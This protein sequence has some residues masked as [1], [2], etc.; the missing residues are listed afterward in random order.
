MKIALMCMAI[1]Y[2]SLFYS[3][4]KKEIADKNYN[5][6]VKFSF[7]KDDCKGE[8]PCTVYFKN[9]TQGDA[10][11][12]WDFG[13]NSEV[14]RRANPQ[15]TYQSGDSFIVKLKVIFKDGEGETTK[16]VIIKE[17]EQPHS[18]P[19]ETIGNFACARKLSS[20]I[21]SH[22]II[23]NE[24]INYYYFNVDTAG[25]VSIKID[26][27]PNAEGGCRFD[28]DLL[29]QPNSSSTV[30]TKGTGLT[31]ETIIMY[32]GPL[33][34]GQY[35]IRLKESS[36]VKSTEKFNITY[37]FL[38][39]DINELNNT[40]YT[41]TNLQDG[42]S[43]KGTILA[44]GDVDYY[45][46]YQAKP[47][48]VDIVLNP[49][50]EFDRASDLTATA[51]DVANT[52]SKVR[53]ITKPTGEI[54]KLSVGPLDTGYHYIALS[55]Y[56]TYSLSTDVYEISA[57]FDT[58]DV[59]EPNNT[60]NVATPINAGQN[61]KGTLKAIEDV[62]IYAYLTTST[63]PITMIVDKVPE[64]LYNF[65]ISL[66][67]DPNQTALV[68]SKKANVGETLTFTSTQPIIL[69]KHYYIKISAYSYEE[70]DEPYIIHVS[71]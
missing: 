50:P 43:L 47:G 34:V 69:G 2:A 33:T 24:K 32:G 61:Y 39:T 41:A 35:Y 38:N 48:V 1:I 66:Y 21:T 62:D 51:F 9:E 10:A 71:Q 42:K 12:E 52:N 31:G 63:Q 27:V 68:G 55:A 26:A 6:D 16:T 23:E 60:F 7:T 45:K 20:G 46:Y 64:Y 40:F 22:G 36:S 56:Y 28:V 65:T 17:P 25:A 58:N 11:Y 57:T 13:D 5:A 37:T 19:C 29:N 4:K 3:C 44:A 70:S 53:S 30:L 14:D 54:L 15:H 18:N 8:T 49:V 67:S 59:N